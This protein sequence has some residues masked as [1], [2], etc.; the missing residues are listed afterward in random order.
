MDSPTHRS[1]KKEIQDAWDMVE[2]NFPIVGHLSQFVE[3]LEKKLEKLLESSE[4]YPLS[5]RW[6]RVSILNRRISKIRFRI[7][8]LKALVNYKVDEAKRLETLEWMDKSIEDGE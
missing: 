4:P 7:Y 3:S 5:I 2:T 8:E 6:L 1:L